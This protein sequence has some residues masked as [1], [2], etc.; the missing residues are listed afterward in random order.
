MSSTKKNYIYNVI[1]QMLLLVIPLITTPYISRVIGAEGSGIYS[2]TY[3]IVQ[4]FGIFA[5]LG[6]N[7]YGNRSVAKIR[8]DKDKLS[9]TFCSIY[10]MQLM[11]T[12]IMTIIY[13]GYIFFINDKY[14]TVAI[15]QII[16]LISVALDINWFFFGME[17]FKITVTRNIVIKIISTIMIFIFVRTRDD[18]YIYILILLLSSLISQLVLW[19]FLKKEIKFVKPKWEEIKVHFKPN[20]ILF[21]P[22]IAVSIYKMMDK[23]MLGNMSN[24]TEVGLYEYAERI[25]N[26]PQGLITALGTVML[27]KM[28]NLVA[29][30]EEE[31]AQGYINRSM[32]FILFASIPMALGIISIAN[33]FVPLFLGEEYIKTGQLLQYLP[34]TIVFISWAQVI[35]SQYLIPK[36]KDKTFI[37]AVC[38][39]AITNFI[40]NYILIPKYQALGAVFGTVAAEF[41]VML[42]HILA[43]IKEVDI[44]QHIKYFINL[45]I[46]GIVMFVA[47][48]IMGRFIE[49][50]MI[51]IVLQVVIGIVIY[52]ALNYKYILTLINK[53][54]IF[55][56][57]KRKI[58]EK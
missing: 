57:F 35:R 18:L 22:V 6:L 20:V 48:E 39:G 28:S 11:T 12:V 27:P 33:D 43:T 32:E 24:M 45:F 53:E 55:N 15:M 17:K 4:Y 13:I 8:D 44:K 42:Y 34:I 31:K 25:Q 7:N 5:M 38:T 49:N 41:V 10:A 2:Y 1:Y 30:G 16:Y 9:R 58:K 36:E 51:R 26:I 23:I 47:I 54:G 14:T 19:K 29:R 52:V 56:G 46:K 50:V 37:M 21:I 3:S 40:L